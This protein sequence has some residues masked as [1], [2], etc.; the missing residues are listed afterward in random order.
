MQKCFDG[1]KLQRTHIDSLQKF[2]SLEIAIFYSQIISLFLYI[3]QC[4]LYVQLKLRFSS[5]IEQLKDDPFWY[6]L[7]YDQNDFLAHENQ[8][9]TC[10]TL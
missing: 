3:A 10:T 5:D 2:R 4:K 1:D 8:I 6:A 7:F 9:M